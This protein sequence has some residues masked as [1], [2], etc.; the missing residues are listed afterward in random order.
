MGLPGLMRFEAE[1]EAGKGRQVWAAIEELASGYPKDDVAATMDQVRADAFVDLVLVNVTVTT[2]VDLAL[3][4]GRLRR[5]FA[6]GMVRGLWRGPASRAGESADAGVQAGGSMLEDRTTG[7]LID[8]DQDADQ[9]AAN[10]ADKDAGRR[11]V[12]RL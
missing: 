3:P 2:V 9:D 11:N 5:S 7:A 6:G 12:L 1:V 8:A 10:E 4:A